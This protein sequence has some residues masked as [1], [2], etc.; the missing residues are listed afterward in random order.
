MRLRSRRSTEATFKL[1]RV[2]GATAGAAAIGSAA[3]RRYSS[4]EEEGSPPKWRTV[5]AS[6][7]LPEL[8][9]LRQF[10][11]YTVYS[12]PRVLKV[13]DVCGCAACKCDRRICRA[14]EVAW[15]TNS[16]AGR[17]ATL[18]IDGCAH[19]ARVNVCVAK[20]VKG[21]KAHTATA[22]GYCTVSNDTAM[23]RRSWLGA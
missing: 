13:D 19:I 8:I 20:L 10:R 15:L 18:S 14:Q 16:A 12:E 1:A 11:R 17:R 9:S 3:L 22:S 21:L 23:A 4:S 5:L 2:G 6:E 7:L